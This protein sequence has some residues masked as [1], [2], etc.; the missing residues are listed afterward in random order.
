[1]DRWIRRGIERACGEKIAVAN[2]T[3]PKEIARLIERLTP[4]PITSLKRFGPLGDGG[5]VIPDDLGGIAACLSPGVSTECGFDDAIAD[6]G[7]DVVMADASVDGPATDNPRFRFFKRFIDVAPSDR[8]MTLAQLAA[9]APADGDLLLQMD[10]EGAEYRVLGAMPDA[11]LQRFRIM[12]IEF[13]G[14]DAMFS[15]F[16]YA[17]VHPVF[18]K[19]ARTHR[20]VHL[21]PNNCIAPIERCGLSVPPVMEFTFYRKDRLGHAPAPQRSFPHP[22]DAPCM[23][24]KPDYALP[25]C[26]WQ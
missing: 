12:V 22:L 8:N 18:E 13:H 17:V 16:G 3:K 25:A 9:Y 15:R 6:M 20:V 7:I 21:H 14:L 24:Q 23:P 1:M 2:A 4:Q 5:Y 19:L 26:W 10:I 11:L